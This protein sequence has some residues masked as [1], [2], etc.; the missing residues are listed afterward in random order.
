MEIAAYIRDKNKRVEIIDV[1][2]E[3]AQKDIIELNQSIKVLDSLNNQTAALIGD[4]SEWLIISDIETELIKDKF[5]ISLI[6]IPWNKLESYKIKEPSDALLNSFRVNERVNLKET[7]KVYSLLDETIRANN[8]SAISVECF[9]MVVSDKV[10]ACLPLSVLNS[11]NV[12]AACEGDICSMLGKMI[13]RAVTNQIPWQA[14]IAEI[15]SDKILF[16]HC[17]APLNMLKSYEI[18]THFETNCGTAIRGVIENQRVGVFRLNN[19]L[20]KY[21]LIEG[22]ITGNPNHDYACRTQIEFTTE[23]NQIELLKDKALGNHQLIFPAFFIPAINR[24]MK[25]LEIKKVI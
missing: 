15:K 7:A 13:I 3:Q 20:D 21:M 11:K 9:S 1:L 23:A 16:A 19:K 8:L 4:I 2:S 6:R 14:N 17:T 12:V 25:Y 22:D 5:G 18:T 10:T 24:L